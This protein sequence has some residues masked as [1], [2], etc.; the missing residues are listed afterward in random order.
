MKPRIGISMNYTVD[1][2]GTERAYLDSPYYEIFDSLSAIAIPIVPTENTIMLHALLGQ[3]DGLLFTGGMDIDPALWNE[4]QHPQTQLIHPKRQRFDLMLYELGIKRKLPILA[5]CLGL[6]IINVAQGGSLHQH[7]PNTAKMNNH[8]S[9]SRPVSHQL[10]INP[11][12][13]L[14]NWF[15]NEE[16]TVASSHHQGIN[17]L[18]N[19]LLA[20]AAAPDGLVEAVELAEYSF[21]LGVQWHPER[22]LSE[23]V[24]RTIIEKFLTACAS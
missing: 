16:I 19:D 10:N 4:Q 15:Q 21:L 9:E 1:E 22:H 8:G 23:H 7:L 18:G 5:I 13:R 17:R 11:Q 14:Y 3:L 24:N 20:A 6:Q 2:N 12:S